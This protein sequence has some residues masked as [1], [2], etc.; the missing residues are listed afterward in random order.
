MV[1]E[2]RSQNLNKFVEQ[3]ELEK[4]NNPVW[5]V[6]SGNPPISNMIINFSMLLNLVSASGLKMKKH[7][8]HSL[9]DIKPN[10]E[11]DKHTDLKKAVKY[12]I[13]YYQ[14]FVKPFKKI[15]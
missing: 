7:C 4:I 2:Y 9:K 1:D 3:T 12:A 10:I 15:S 11:A 8:G 5:H 6:H 14:D 13:N